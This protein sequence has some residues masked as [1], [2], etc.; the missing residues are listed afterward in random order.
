[1][2]LDALKAELNREMIEAQAR[3]R[4]VDLVET[5]AEAVRVLALPV[6]LQVIGGALV[7]RVTVFDPMVVTYELA[8]GPTMGDALSLMQAET[9][10]A[11]VLQDDAVPVADPAPELHTGP[12]TE[13]E[14]AEA[15][16]L[17]ARGASLKEIAAALNRPAASLNL[18]M[19]H[20]RRKVEEEIEDDDTAPDAGQGD[21]QEACGHA[22]E[23]TEAP[24]E[25]VADFTPAALPKDAPVAMKLVQAHLNAAGYQAPWTPELDYQLI[26]GLTGGRKLPAVAGDLGLS[27]EDCR[28]RFALLC[29]EPGFEAQSRLLKVL[30]HRA[31]QTQPVKE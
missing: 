16:E 17:D 7:L 2:S 4:A 8:S 21:R 19:R 12:W 30:Q 26:A 22:P 20:L 24:A 1:M 27:L 29:P 28:Q 14:E 18:K 23:G 5:A 25:A 31:G 13:D 9:P 15:L 3:Q 10:Q 11:E 6:E